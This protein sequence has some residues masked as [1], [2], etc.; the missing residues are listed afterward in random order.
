MQ[1]LTQ[2]IRKM[3]DLKKIKN[4]F[5][6]CLLYHT[7]IKEGPNKHDEKKKNRRVFFKR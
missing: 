2:K 5:F 1:R 4:K 6:R 3:S 7:K